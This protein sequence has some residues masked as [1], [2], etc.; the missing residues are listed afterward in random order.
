MRR[1]SS[2][3]SAP[4]AVVAAAL[5]LLAPSVAYAHHLPTSTQMWQLHSTITMQVTQGYPGGD[6]VNRLDSARNEWNAVGTTRTITRD[7]NRI[8]DFNPLAQCPP[9]VGTMTVHWIET[10]SL[11]YPNALGLSSYCYYIPSG[12]RASSWMVFDTD[13]DWYTGTGDANDGFLNL[14]VNGCQID[15]WSIISHEQG[16]AMGFG[17]FSGSDSVCGDNSGEH[18]MCPTY[19]GGTERW[20]TYEAHEKEAFNIAY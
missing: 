8:A 7:A 16:H 12:G 17:H 5:L 1:L 15:L 18:T 2:A 3:W 6:H 9:N 13:Q 11:G 20:R 4:G 10:S 19:K 14:C